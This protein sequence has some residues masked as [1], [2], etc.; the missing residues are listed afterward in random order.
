MQGSQLFQDYGLSI[1][2]SQMRTGQRGAIDAIINNVRH[3]KTH[4]AIVLPPRY[5]KSDVIRGAG[6]ILMLQKQVSRC[7]IL[8]PAEVLRHQIIDRPKMQEAADR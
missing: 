5:G 6:V 7:L 3:E 2:L 4:T 8:E 1:D